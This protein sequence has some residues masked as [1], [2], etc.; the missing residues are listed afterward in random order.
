MYRLLCATEDQ[1]QK[2]KQKNQKKNA[3]LLFMYYV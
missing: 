1:V 3:N 2:K